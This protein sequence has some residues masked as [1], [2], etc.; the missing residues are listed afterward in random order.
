LPASYHKEE[1]SQKLRMISD[2]NDQINE[3][4]KNIIGCFEGLKNKL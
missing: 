3:R 4:I 2:F 1:V